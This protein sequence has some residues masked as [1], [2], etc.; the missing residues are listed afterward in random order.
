MGERLAS[1][2][3]LPQQLERLCLD[4]ADVGAADT[5]ALRHLLLGH[6]L[7]T[8]QPVTQHDHGLLALAERLADEPSELLRVELAVKVVEDV[9][10]HRHDVHQRQRIAVLVGV[11]GL[12]E[13]HILRAFLRGAEVHEDLVFNAAAGIGA[14]TDVFVGIEGVDRLDQPDGADGHQIVL[15]ILPAVVFFNDVRDEPQ[16]V[17]DQEPA[18]V[19]V[20]FLHFQKVFAFLFLRQRLRELAAAADVQDKE[21]DVLSQKGDKVQHKLRLRSKVF[22]NG[23]YVF[24]LRNIRIAAIIEEERGEG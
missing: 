24:L 16:V 18:R 14:E 10:V 6:R 19:R 5:Q 23:V 8:V 22:F 11:D 13:R 1:L 15:L 4:A 3:S 12:V 21:T 7:L 2:I 20:A 17:L 9:I